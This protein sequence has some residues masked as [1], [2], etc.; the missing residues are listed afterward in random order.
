[1][2]IMILRLSAFNFIFRE[3]AI[4]FTD[5]IAIVLFKLLPS[6]SCVLCT[7][8]SLTKNI[9]GKSAVLFSV[10]RT[11]FIFRMFDILVALLMNRG[12]KIFK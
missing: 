4:I 12:Y 7:I 6:F 2:F 9:T 8:Q 1:M 11:I 10:V 5:L 3:M